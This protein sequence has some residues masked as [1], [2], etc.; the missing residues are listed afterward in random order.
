MCTLQR[1]PQSL[2]DIAGE[3][4]LVHFVL[5]FPCPWVRI[6]WLF[7]LDCWKLAYELILKCM[8]HSTVV[9]KAHGPQVMVML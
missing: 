2:S 8:L 6:E 7:S 5:F 1:D 9:I 3:G 4:S